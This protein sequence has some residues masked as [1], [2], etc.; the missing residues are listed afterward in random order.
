[1]YYNASFG[2]YKLLGIKIY[3]NKMIEK[4]IYI[5]KE[6]CKT[7]EDFPTVAVI[8]N[9]NLL[10]KIS[11]KKYNYE[12]EH[13]ELYFNVA[14]EIYVK[15]ADDLERISEI[16]QH[17]MN[18]SMNSSQL[19]ISKVLIKP[20]YDKIQILNSEISVVQTAWEEI[21]SLQNKIIAD[22]K[23]ANI[24]IDF[25]N[26]GNSSRIIM[27]KLARIVFNP[28]LHKANIQV[29]LSNGKFKNQFHTYIACELNGE[30]NKEL[31]Q[32]S[33]SA[34]TFT[35]KAIDLMNQTTHKL[36]IQRHFAEVCVISTISVISLIK[37]VN[38]IQNIDKA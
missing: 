26:I 14:P 3:P 31:R 1:M 36:D 20:N 33:E 18:R 9:S 11:K 12:A 21:N 38:E 19:M 2:I 5:V 24:S 22:I 16:I 28:E 17:Y 10:H 29:D 7:N 23:R 30:Q 32:F 4:V 34:I 6:I 35:E 37:A 8:E 27:D 13:I 25:Q 15:Y